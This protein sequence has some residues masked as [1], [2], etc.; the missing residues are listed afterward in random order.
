MFVC[1]LH[2]NNKHMYIHMHMY[3]LLYVPA[4]SATK[5]QQQTRG[6]CSSVQY[7][8][9]FSMDFSFFVFLLFLLSSPVWAA[10]DE[11]DEAACMFFGFC[12]VCCY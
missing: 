7:S 12:V 10:I 3:V 8:V 11:T 2:D 5:S 4:E 6:H 1:E 9:V